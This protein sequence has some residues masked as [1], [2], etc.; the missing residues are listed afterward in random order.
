VR[1]HVKHSRWF[2]VALAAL[3]L[4]CGSASGKGAG[5][6]VIIGPAT[7]NSGAHL[8]RVPSGSMEP[9]YRIGSRVLVASGP[10]RLGA[11]VILHPPRGAEQEQCGPKPHLFVFRGGAC[12]Q[13]VPSE[14]T[15]VSF[16]KRIVAGP[17]DEIYIRE[18]HVFRKQAGQASFIREQDPYIKECTGAL[19]RCDFET[20]VTIPAGHW[21]LL[22]DNRGES[23]DSRF[24]GPIPAAWIIG[25]VNGLPLPP[26]AGIA[27]ELRAQC[28]GGVVIAA[29]GSAKCLGS[30]HLALT[31]AAGP[32]ER[33]LSEITLLCRRQRTQCHRIFEEGGSGE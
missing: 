26:R 4:G 16:I 12:S 1:A 25:V 6:T 24:W 7:G 15:G 28:P 20:P 19:G 9:S 32:L 33:Q 23:D 22:G 18:G 10:P 11:V 2:P 13:P 17:G 31:V 3:L 27:A 5:T 8:Y 30:G 21:F 14:D 29:T